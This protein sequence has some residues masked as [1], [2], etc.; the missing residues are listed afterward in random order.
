MGQEKIEYKKF[1]YRSLPSWAPGRILTS[2]RLDCMKESHEI[3]EPVRSCDDDMMKFLNEKMVEMFKKNI[4]YVLAMEKIKNAILYRFYVAGPEK[5]VV[6]DGD[7][8]DE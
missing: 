2:Y 5:E 3:C 8:G 4:P 1:N 6:G 7:G